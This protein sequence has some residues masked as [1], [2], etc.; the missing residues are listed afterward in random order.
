M[1]LR[2]KKRRSRQDKIG[3]IVCHEIQVRIQNEK[4]IKQ[5]GDK[6]FDPKKLEIQSCPTLLPVTI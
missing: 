1:N 5:E 3:S 2:E 4:S 6:N